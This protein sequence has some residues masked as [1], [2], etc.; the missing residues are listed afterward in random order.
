M[1]ENYIVLF[2]NAKFDIPMLA[3]A[4]FK[5]KNTIVDVLLVAQLVKP[6][7]KIRKLK[8]M[9]RKY[10]NDPFIEDHNMRKWLKANKG[11][12]Q[13][14]APRHIVV[15]YALADAKKTLELFYYLQP[16]LDDYK[17]WSVLEREMALM[18]IVLKMENSGFRVDTNEVNLLESRVTKELKE[19]R[20]EITKIV[21]NPAFNP[22]SNPQVV[23][24]VYTGDCMPTSFSN[25]TGKPKVDEL[26][27]LKSPSKVGSLVVKYRKLVKAKSTYLKPLRNL[28]RLDILRA[29]FN[30]GAAKTG[31]FSSSGPNL[32]NIPRPGHGL[33]GEIKKCFIPR[34]G[35]RLVFV[36]YKQIEMRLTAH[37]SGEQHMLDAINSGKDLHDETCFLLFPDE[38]KEDWDT[39]RYLSKKLNFSIIYGVGGSKFADSVLTD[40]EGRVNLRVEEAYGIIADYKSK[41]PAIEQLFSD[42]ITEVSETGGVRNFY[43]RFIPTDPYKSYAGVNYKIQGTAADFIK[44]KM[45][46]VNHFLKVN[47]LSA[48]LIGQVHDELIFDI[49]KKERD[50]VPHLV[51]LME[52]YTTFKVP[53]ICSVAIGSS[54]FNKKDIRIPG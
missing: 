46:V 12:A 6:D 19:I 51:K 30:Q 13:G 54:W 31:R 21:G 53:I 22:N 20:T 33:L 9:S 26:A 14:E 44:Q 42:T 10:L 11:K 27:L 28:D 4:G 1:E 39:Y 50:I 52:D 25:K 15:P 29:S 24:A 49:P 37:F 47:K 45:L 8:Q 38:S 18:P 34:E 43:D 5:L 41:H 16:G 2:F 40:T 7:D 23:D 3:K 35:R 17:L 36:D 32:Q 48:L